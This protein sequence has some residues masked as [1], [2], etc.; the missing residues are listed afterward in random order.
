MIEIEWMEIPA[1][2]FTM[3]SA[4]DDEDAAD[5]EKPQHRLRLPAFYISRYPITV[6]QLQH[7]ATCTGFAY[8]P[9]PTSISND[10]PAIGVNWYDAMTFCGWLSKMTGEQITLPSEAEWEK[11]ARGTDGRIYPWGDEPPDDT[12][13]NFDDNIGHL[14]PVG[15]YPKGASPYGVLDMSGNVWEWTR[16]AFEHYPYDPSDGREDLEVG[17]DVLRVMRG[18]AFYNSQWR[19]RCASRRGDDPYFRNWSIGFRVVRGGAFNNNRRNVRCASRGRVNP[20]FRYGDFGFR[21]VRHA[22][23]AHLLSVVEWVLPPWPTFAE[24]GQEPFCPACGQLQKEGHRVDCPLSALLSIST[25]P[26]QAAM[27]LEIAEHIYYEALLNGTFFEDMP[28][29]N[30]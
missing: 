7:F 10:Y 24:E 4:G 18:G 5:Y 16:S 30:N 19:M 22:T 29:E 11:A 9:P 15:Q 20:D 3:G 28:D 26:D 2:D 25:V 12:R 1:G 17:D 23:L 14:T 21:V 13:C 8:S 6:A 27:P